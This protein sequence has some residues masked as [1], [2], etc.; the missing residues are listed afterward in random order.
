M[1]LVES[2]I[3]EAKEK[4]LEKG[5]EEGLEQGHEQGHEQGLQEGIEKG[6]LS[7]VRRLLISS[8][9]DDEKIADLAAVGVYW[10]RRQIGRASWRTRVYKYVEIWV[11]V[12]AF[13][14]DKKKRHI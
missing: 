6:K 14:K 13:N 2:L 9:F 12:V 10:V 11:V 5:L 4:G 8:D 7:V 3:S 1:G